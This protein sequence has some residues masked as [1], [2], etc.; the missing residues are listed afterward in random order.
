MTAMIIRQPDGKLAVFS[1][2]TSDW[3]AK[4]LTADEVEALFVG[5]MLREVEERRRHVR[6]KIALVAAGKA[7]EAYPVCS[8]TYEQADAIALTDPD[9]DQP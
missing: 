1:T 4:G 9:E 8:M 5:D 3:I 2:N 6:E 7:D